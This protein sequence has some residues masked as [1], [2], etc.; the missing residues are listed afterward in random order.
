MEPEASYES[1]VDERRRRIMLKVNPKVADSFQQYLVRAFT[2]GVATLVAVLVQNGQ[3][4]EA[5]I[6]AEKALK[7]M[8]DPAFESQ[9]E[10]AKSGTVPTPWP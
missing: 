2:H 7:E 3:A 5:V 8:P 10:K 9:I 6:I 4:E 1:L